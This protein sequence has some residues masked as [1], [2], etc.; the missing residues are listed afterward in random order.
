MLRMS[1]SLEK[2]KVEAGEED[3]KEDQEDHKEEEVDKG[4]EEKEDGLS[5]VGSGA[6]GGEPVAG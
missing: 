5:A 3:G 4:D 6:G 2:D 1:E